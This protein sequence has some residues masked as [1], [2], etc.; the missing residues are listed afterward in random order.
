MTASADTDLTHVAPIDADGATVS[1]HRICALDQIEALIAEA[2]AGGTSEASAL[3][4]IG[5]IARRRSV[6]VEI[7]QKPWG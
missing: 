1:H 6:P 7:Y 5:Q 4:A 3:R 2:R